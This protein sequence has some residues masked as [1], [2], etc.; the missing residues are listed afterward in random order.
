MCEDSESGFAICVDSRAPCS[1]V[2]L[3]TVIFNISNLSIFL[4]IKQLFNRAKSLQ[5]QTF[6]I[7]TSTV[8]STL[9][10]TTITMA[11]ISFALQSCTS[12]M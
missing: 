1:A 9:A 4:L 7:N 8:S 12:L 11:R 10:Y 5:N 6:A 3:Y 2:M